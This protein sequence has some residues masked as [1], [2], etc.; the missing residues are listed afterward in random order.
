MRLEK[1]MR[2]N[3]CGWLAGV[4]MF[5]V[6]A[7]PNTALAA[8]YVQH[9]LV[10]D[11]PLL[12]DNTDPNLVN[13]W[14][15][16][17][18]P[19]IWICNNKTGTFNVY[20]ADG[21][22]SATQTSVPPAPGKPAPGRCTGTV[23]N[24]NNAAFQ[25]S[26][27]VNGTFITAT[28]DGVI[29]VRVGATNVIKIDNSASGAVYK[30]L[31][32]SNNPLINNPPDL[33]YAA[34]FHSGKIEVYDGTYTAATLAG[35][36]TD[37]GVPAGF[38]PFNI[39]NLGGKLYVAYAKQDASAQNDVAGAGN[40]YVSVF[41]LNGNLLQHLISNGQLNSPWGMV[42][43]P[44]TFGE[45]ANDLLVGNF[46]DGTINAYDA[47]S[48]QYF[49]TV[50]DPSGKPIA[51]IGLWA[52]WF[53]GGGNGGDVTKLYFTAGIS[54]GTG[55]QSHGLFATISVAATVGAA[56][57][58]NLS[59]TVN[60][61][62]FAAGTNA[63]A[64]GSIAAIFGTNLTDGTTCV[65]PNCNPTLD[66]GNPRRLRTTMAGAQVLI[67]GFPTPMFYASPNQLGIELPT[68][69]TGDSATVQVVVNGQASTARA[70]SIGPFSPGVFTLNQQ[71]T[72]AAAATH[73][74][75]TPVNAASPAARGETIILYATGLGQVTPAVVTG[76][77]STGLTSTVTKPIVL[78][79]NISAD[80]PF[81]GLSNCCVALNQVN[82]TV[83]STARVGTDVSVVLTIGGQQANPVTIATK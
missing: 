78:I 52:L 60:N 9:N 70:V 55:I 18:L 59:G 1:M 41:D 80:V 45:F 62:S 38:A 57:A 72:G 48:G 56:P 64:A 58:V 34:N 36:F 35:S 81:F 28:E 39:T 29:A 50:V 51:N 25:S 6:G 14:G 22:P 12:A 67:N 76:A 66:N 65:Q 69:L 16:F 3:L 46:R 44:A 15:A 23:R 26:P 75:G 53:G 30:G 74:D 73:G 82:V 61:A 63:M 31:A 2:R 47:A 33:I 7:G 37:P 68:D 11:V 27:G 49:G 5:L 13:P 79:D 43:A 83:P 19:A 71:G 32:I 10:S 17:P 54:N 4:A 21:T 8:G 20:S 40:G 42:I 24:L 77:F